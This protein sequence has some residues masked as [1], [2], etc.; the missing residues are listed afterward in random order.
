MKIKLIPLLFIIT[1]CLSLAGCKTKESIEVAFITD[2]GT[3]ED[4]QYNENCY[5]GL[6]KFCDEKGTKY[7]AYVPEGMWLKVI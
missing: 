4:A 7:K 6:V 1:V 3:V 5:A 2:G